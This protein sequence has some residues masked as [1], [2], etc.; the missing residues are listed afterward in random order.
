VSRFTPSAGEWHRF[1]GHPEW[2]YQEGLHEDI[3]PFFDGMI[4]RP[5]GSIANPPPES[6]T[7]AAEK[8][9]RAI[10]RDLRDY[11]KGFKD[12]LVKG[13]LD[14]PSGGDC[15]FCSMFEQAGLHDSGHLREHIA[16]DERYYVPSLLFNA[17]QERGYGDWKFVMS[18]R[19]DREAYDKGV[20]KARSDNA[21]NDLIHD[22]RRY[23]KKRLLPGG[24]VTPVGVGITTGAG[25]GY[26]GV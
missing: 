26:Y 2:D 4:L 21:A 15:W 3:G 22:V 8:E 1:E 19:L 7:I 20:L 16:K 12:A 9:R 10:E 24:G 13:E 6:A 14:V 23:L 18:M 25:S 11:L 17:V 5:D